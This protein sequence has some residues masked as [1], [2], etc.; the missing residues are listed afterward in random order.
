VNAGNYSVLVEAQDNIGLIGSDLVLFDAAWTPPPVPSGIAISATSFDSLGYVTVGWNA[1]IIDTDFHAWRVYRREEGTDEVVLA[2]ET[3]N[4]LTD[5]FDDWYVLSGVPYEYNVVQVANRFGA[6]IESVVTWQSPVTGT[7]SHYWLLH[8][9]DNTKNIKVFH[10]ISDDFTEE[11]ESETTLLIGRGRKVDFGSR[12]GYTGTLVCQ[13]RGYDGLTARQ[14][15]K[16]IEAIKAELRE[17]FLRNP[18]GDL[19]QV[20]IGDLQVSRLSGVGTNE[21]CTVTVPYQEVS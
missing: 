13:I 17:V 1:A 6:L 18:F 9:D 7:S 5:T 3:T 11:Y 4:P 19:W 20:S 10:V 21:Y 2:Y 14:I 16:N 12:W 8:P 15:K